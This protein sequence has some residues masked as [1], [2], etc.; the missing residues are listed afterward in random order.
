MAALFAGAVGTSG[1]VV[2]A[3]LNED[4]MRVGR[5]RLLNQGL[6]QIEFCRTPAESLP[7]ADDQ[8]TALHQLRL[9]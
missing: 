1:R 5:D 6:T 2:L 4:M 7:F 9:T 8:L 3:D